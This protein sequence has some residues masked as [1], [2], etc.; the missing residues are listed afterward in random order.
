MSLPYNVYPFFDNILVV[1]YVENTK[2]TGKCELDSHVEGSVPKLKF[3][4]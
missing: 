4:T 2:K 3:V 1:K